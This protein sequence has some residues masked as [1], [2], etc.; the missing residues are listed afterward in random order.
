MSQ[1]EF[2]LWQGAF[3]G[4]FVAFAAW[5]VARINR[6]ATNVRLNV[7]LWIGG[8][9]V[10][11]A[12][13]IGYRFMALKLAATEERMNRPNSLR[14]LALDWGIGMSV[15]KRTEHSL[16][17][18]KSVFENSG[19]IFDYIDSEGR[20][21]PFVPSRMDRDNRKMRL[22]T[23][24][25]QV[26]FSATASVVWLFV[27]LAMSGFMLRGVSRQPRLRSTGTTD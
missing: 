26:T 22:S 14:P 13:A 9:V 1:T 16:T 23:V 17:L 6:R 11:S 12:F 21:V 18:A 27:P 19:E 5:L 3:V 7:L 25:T 10:S 15:E 2:W 20:L 8:Y 4:G 24:S